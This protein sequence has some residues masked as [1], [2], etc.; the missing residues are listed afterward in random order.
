MEIK[1]KWGFKNIKPEEKRTINNIQK[2]AIFKCL[3]FFSR[4]SHFSCFYKF[5]KNNFR[6]KF[7]STFDIELNLNLLKIVLL[8][9]IFNIDFDIF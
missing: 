2:I 1:F 5:F 7:F 6:T 9:I 4:N 8:F 3:K